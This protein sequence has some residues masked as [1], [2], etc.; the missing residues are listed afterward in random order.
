LI[1]Q[2]NLSSHQDQQI[3][4]NSSNNLPT[5]QPVQSIVNPIQ[6]VVN[7]AQSV[8]NSIPINFQS[9][10]A[11]NLPNNS[12]S[13]RMPNI[14]PVP[15]T[16]SNRTQPPPLLN[17]QRQSPS[18][19]L[20]QPQFQQTSVR[21]QHQ[22]LSRTP[23]MIR[24]IN[25]ISSPSRLAATPPPRTQFF[26]Q[27]LVSQ[28]TLPSQRITSPRNNFISQRSTPFPQKPINITPRN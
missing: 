15:L 23:P 26:Q 19:I 6:N 21:S 14:N 3:P 18:R 5:F 2:S 25:Q 4:V 27:N 9:S 17:L 20:P 8:A 22:H 11:V 1:N 10:T 7:P 12:L 28:N 24:P 13:L 16:I